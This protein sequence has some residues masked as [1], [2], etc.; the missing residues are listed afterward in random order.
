VLADR[1]EV[2]EADIAR[3]AKLYPLNACPIQNLNRRFILASTRR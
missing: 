3:F 1:I 2:A